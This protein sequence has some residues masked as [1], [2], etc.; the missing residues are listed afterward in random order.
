MIQSYLK[1]KRSQFSN[2]VLQLWIFYSLVQ[3][4]PYARRGIYLSSLLPLIFE[5]T[6]FKS[7]HVGRT[8][9]LYG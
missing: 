7:L 6:N 2:E 4:P 3:S 9:Y 1:D 8:R 5:A